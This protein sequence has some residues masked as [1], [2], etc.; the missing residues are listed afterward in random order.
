[1][2]KIT[3]KKLEKF[4]EKYKTDDHILDLGAGKVSTNHSYT[5]YFPNRH[6]VDIDENR[7]PDTVADLH[8]LPFENESYS[9]IVCTEVLEHCH[10][11][12][13]VLNEMHRV[14]KLGGT[15][16]LTTRFVYPLHDIPHDYYRFTKYGLRYLLSDWNV[17]EIVPETETFTAIA[18]LVQRIGFQSNLRGGKFTKALL[19][20]GAFILQ[21]MDWLI[22]SEYGDITK[23]HTETN[24]MTTGYYLVAQK[25]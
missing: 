21:Y 6:T 5:R 8:K 9:T 13:T 2:K 12:E 16:I 20:S 14:L 3:R 4:L 24:I 11:P 19:Y 18:A 15:L 23:K 25:K 10:S 1:M 17:I 22:K 7:K